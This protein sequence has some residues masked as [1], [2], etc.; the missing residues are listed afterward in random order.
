MKW[1]NHVAIA[2]ATTAVVSPIMAPVAILGA[3]APDWIEWIIKGCGGHVRH[4]QTTHYVAVWLIALGALWAFDPTG[5]GAAF[6]YG[7]LTHTLTDAMTVTGVPFSPLSSQRF[8]LFGGRFR[9]GDAVEY[10][11]AFGI[12]AICAAIALA[13]SS[14]HGGWA[15]FF[16]DWAGLYGSGVVDGIEWRMN[17]FRFF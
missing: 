3:T 13:T 12:V 9:T 2:G 6:A 7:G 4:R 17:R 8:H 14:W 10:G 11:I 15:P 16:Y 5:I 1:I